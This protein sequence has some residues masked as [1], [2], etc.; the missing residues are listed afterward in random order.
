MQKINITESDFSNREVKTTN[1]DPNMWICC[2]Q[3]PTDSRLL[4][5]LIT[6]FTIL[7]LMA[8]CIVMLIKNESCES[9]QAYLGLLTLLIGVMMPNPKPAKP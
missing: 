8:F 9:Q 3:R 1:A 4:K 7:I 5:Y 2:R 6:V